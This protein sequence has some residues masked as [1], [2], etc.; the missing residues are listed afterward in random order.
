MVEVVGIDHVCIGT[1]TKMTP[2]YRPPDN[3]GPP[4]GNI[5]QPRTDTVRPD[6]KP[7]DKKNN[8]PGKNGPRVGE[9]TNEAWQNQKVGF[10][11]AVVG[12]LL[13]VGFSEKDIEK[14]GG[15]NYCR[16]FNVATSD[17]RGIVL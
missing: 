5:N 7:N 8:G 2:S 1:D 4:P 12:A 13:E 16:I 14:I 17:R 9:R 10:Y 15:G 6:G 3:L 11:Y